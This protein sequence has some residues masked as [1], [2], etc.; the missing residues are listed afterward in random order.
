MLG[1]LRNGELLPWDRDIDIVILTKTNGYK[2]LMNLM[3]AKGFQ[4]GFHRKFRPGLPVFKFYR[5]GGRT[6]EFN[7]YIKNLK[8][9]YCL[10]WYEC[11]ILEIYKKLKLYQKFIYKLLKIIGRIPIQEVQLGLQ[12]CLYVDNKLKKIIC[13]TLKN[14]FSSIYSISLWLRKFATLDNLVGYYSVNLDPKKS[15]IIQY[16]GLDCLIPEKSEKV[17][18]DFYG[19][20]WRKARKSLNY[21]YF[22]KKN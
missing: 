18:A 11:E 5:T 17:C 22:F 20:D 1:L 21:S 6:I 12:P 14:F 19:P 9:E 10:E 7:I 8:G 2:E 4:G 15:R 16:H 3:K 13:H